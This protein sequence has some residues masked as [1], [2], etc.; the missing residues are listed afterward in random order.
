MY[1]SP[2]LDAPQRF[3]MGRFERITSA[4]NPLVRQIRRAVACGGLTEDG[5]CVAETFH[6]L[7][8]ALRSDCGIRAV[9]AAESARAAAEP[10]LQRLGR[11]RALVVPDRLFGALA[12][13]ATSQGILALVQAPS[14]RPAQVFREEALVVVLDG[15]Q[16]PGNAGAI[17]R[18]AEA[19]GAT[20][21]VFV[22]G[23]T[24]PFNPKA[25]RASA[26]SVF[27]LPLLWGLEPEAVRAAL[28]QNGLRAYAATPRA[29][30]TLFEAEIKVP[31]AV[32]IGSES[33]GVSEALRAEA[34]EVRIPTMRVESLNA[35]VAAGI[36]LW[37]AWRQRAPSP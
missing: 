12:T 18:V 1:R 29:R 14:W 11:V 22:K 15:I 37:E 27:R 16:E 6:L 23:T 26:G 4:A 34:V 24:S 5:C 31:A 25:V 36:L 9:L 21:A 20:G 2:G 33:R 3:S 30:M 35:A 13:L 28:Q 7:E 10:Y 19:F 32:I 17:L 8:E